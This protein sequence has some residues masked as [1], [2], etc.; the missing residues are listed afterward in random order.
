M[1]ATAD[2]FASET[3]LEI[4]DDS[5]TVSTRRGGRQSGHFKV[6]KAESVTLVIATD[7][8]GPD[9]PQTF[10]FLDNGTMKWA[11]FD[12]KGAG[13]TAIACERGCAIVFA[14]Q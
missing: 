12:P 2:A 14:K 8:D 1:Q 7:K 11:V 3:E 5:I 10:T 13:R 9:D 4:K 6:V